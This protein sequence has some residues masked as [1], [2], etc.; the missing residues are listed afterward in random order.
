[1]KDITIKNATGS[2]VHNAKLHESGVIEFECG[3][4]SHIAYELSFGKEVV[5]LV[6]AK[7]VEAPIEAKPEEPSDK[8]KK[9]ATKKA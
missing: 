6:E 9:R 1:M 3:K 2:Q 4:I 5:K 8:T 7:K